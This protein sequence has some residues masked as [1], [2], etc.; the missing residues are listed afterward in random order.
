MRVPGWDT[1]YP[2]P[3][4]EDHYVPSVERVLRRPCARRGG[5]MA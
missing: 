2:M 1:P 5:V 4:V 3:L